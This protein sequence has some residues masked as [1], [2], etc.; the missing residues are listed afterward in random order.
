MIEKK[1]SLEEILGPLSKYVNFSRL[2]IERMAYDRMMKKEKRG[3]EGEPKDFQIRTSDTLFIV[4]L[5]DIQDYF[6][7]NPAPTPVMT[8]KQELEYLREKVKKAE[9]DDVVAEK[10]EVAVEPPKRKPGRPPKDKVGVGTDGN[11]PVTDEFPQLRNTPPK[12]EKIPQKDIRKELAEEL[13]SQQ[14]D[15]QSE[16]K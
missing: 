10:Q 13:K 7:K 15:D 11:L 14:A 8:E 5:A 6:T 3:S 2:A 4:K 1:V 9:M 12:D 16:E